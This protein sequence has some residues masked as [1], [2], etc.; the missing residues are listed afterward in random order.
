[1][2]SPIPD[3]KSMKAAECLITPWRLHT[4]I[5]GIAP[6]DRPLTRSEGYR[7]QAA[8]AELTG[9][10]EIGWKIA[11]TNIAGVRREEEKELSDARILGDGEFVETGLNLE[12]KEQNQSLMS[13]AQ[14]AGMVRAKT[15]VGLD[16]IRSLSRVRKIV[17][18][19]ALYCFLAKEKGGVSGSELM[20]DLRLTSG[21]V[22]HLVSVG[23][24]VI[25]SQNN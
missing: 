20:K 12:G 9:D 1:M 10:R 17:K 24:E 14:I 11:V 23:R 3:M 13:L 8:L 6:D 5:A 19:W 16:E 21:A 22:S 25:R 2:K 18:A 4:R 7:V 15:W